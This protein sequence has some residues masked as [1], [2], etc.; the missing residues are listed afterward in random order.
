MTTTMADYGGVNEEPR[1]RRSKRAQAESLHESDAR[2]GDD[3]LI[4][5]VLR[6]V[7]EEGAGYRETAYRVL[8]STDYPEKYIRIGVVGL[9]AMAAD[10]QRRVNHGDMPK[11]KDERDQ[12]LGRF[13]PQTQHLTPADW[14]T[15]ERVRL[16]GHDGFIKPLSVFTIEDAKALA[17]AAR[18]DQAGAKARERFAHELEAMLTKHKAS[19]WRDLP[20][21][22]QQKINKLAEGAWS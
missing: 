2:F 11:D 17:D 21:T 16:M 12:F 20:K 6:I 13:R 7:D 9:A 5:D 15:M 3:A 19:T 8:S 22:V 18:A 4:A 14:L 1:G 10:I